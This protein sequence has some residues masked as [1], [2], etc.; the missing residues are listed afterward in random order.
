[1]KVLIVKTSS[2]GDIIH[3]FPALSDAVKAYPTIQFDWVIEE[4]FQNIARWHSSV[5]TVLPIALRRWRKQ[6]LQSRSDI[7]KRLQAIRN[8]SYDKIIDAQ[9]LLKSAIITNIA[10][11]PSA[12]FNWNS[13]REPIASLFYQQ[14]Y[15]VPWAQHAVSR[16]RTLLAQALG[17]STPN[18]LPQYGIDIS[19]LPAFSDANPYYVFLHGTTWTTKHWPESYWISLASKVVEKGNTVFLPWGTLPERAR[20]ERIRAATTLPNSVKILPK[21][22]LE[23]IGGVLAGAHAVVSVDTG[24]GHLAAA[25]AVPTVSLY[26]PTDAQKTGLFGQHQI[27]LSASYSCAPCFSRICTQGGEKP[28]DPPC[29][30]TVSPD[31]V[32]EQLIQI[33]N[34]T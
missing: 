8:H 1:M 22:N 23:E 14:K 30:A 29:F 24:L 11:G 13:A 33:K 34:P 10:R 3:T 2:L 7:K 9:G 15:S 16:I 25:L 6:W 18:D 12:G 26:G 17:Y 21:M 28:V 4:S 5:Q 19:R 31:R 32:W 27:H 20:A